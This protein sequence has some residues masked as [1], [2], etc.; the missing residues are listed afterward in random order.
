MDIMPIKLSLIMPASSIR[1]HIA[2]LIRVQKRK[3]LLS[4]VGS[5]IHVVGPYTCNLMEGQVC[6]TLSDWMVALM[7]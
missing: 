7:F 1:L 3:W 6:S 5:S 2:G 4:W